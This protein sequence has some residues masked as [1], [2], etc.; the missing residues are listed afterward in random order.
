MKKLIRSVSILL[1]LCLLLSVG[2]MAAGTSKVC[3]VKEGDMMFTLPEGLR[4]MSVEECEAFASPETYAQTIAALLPGNGLED[5]DIYTQV[6]T[7]ISSLEEGNDRAFIGLMLK[8][9]G[10]SVDET[11]DYSIMDDDTADILNVI[12]DAASEAVSESLNG[13]D[14]KM[15]F[16]KNE[17]TYYTRIR[18][19]VTAAEDNTLWIDGYATGKNGE[20]Y[21]YVYLTD[22]KEMRLYG[23]DIMKTMVL[24]RHTYYP[25][26]FPDLK[27]HWAA[28]NAAK[29]V[30]LGLFKGNTATEFAPDNAMTRAMLVQVLY[31]MQGSPEAGTS[32]FSDVADDAWYAKAVAW[33]SEN[34]IVKGAG[35]KFDPD[36]LLTREQLA[37]ILWRYAK[38]EERDVSVGEDTNILSYK[39]AQDVSSYAVSPLQW[40]CG[41]GL[42]KGASGKLMPQNTTTRAQ[43]ATI[44]VR[45]L[46]A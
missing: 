5:E 10:F 12:F 42:I 34:G 25:G 45:Y 16:W 20:M 28:E 43:V 2:A 30:E 26:G 31:R 27:G 11:M 29:S 36:G 17:Q 3:T 14:V 9:G 1:C 24:E 15:G 7:G 38:F 13:I 37:A 18:Y 21:V 41:E 6:L 8:I 4:Q 44:L 35:G 23:E 32:K 40:A 19:Q 33:A 46:A 22:Q 39:D